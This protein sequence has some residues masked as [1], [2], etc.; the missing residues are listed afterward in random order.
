MKP[1]LSV[2]V[3]EESSLISQRYY[4]PLCPPSLLSRPPPSSLL[5]CSPGSSSWR[6]GLQEGNG[7]L[8]P[9]SQVRLNASRPLPPARIQALW[10]G[11]WFP[12]FLFSWSPVSSDLPDFLMVHIHISKCLYSAFTCRHICV[13]ITPHCSSQTPPATS[14]AHSVLVL[15]QQVLQLPLTYTFIRSHMQLTGT[16]ILQS[17]HYFLLF[18]WQNDKIGR[19]IDK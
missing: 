2:I 16:Q 15:P 14:T 4:P 1:C 17:F 8:V 12:L 7:T 3:T 11:P 13:P 18:Y 9:V 19:W 5:H 10:I 6:S